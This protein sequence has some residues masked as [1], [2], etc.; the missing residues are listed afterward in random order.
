MLNIVSES[1]EIIN[2]DVAKIL[3]QMGIS[4]VKFKLTDQVTQDGLARDHSNPIHV[5]SLNKVSKLGNVHK[6]GDMEHL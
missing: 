4:K 5:F 6:P 2:M 3:D 1:K